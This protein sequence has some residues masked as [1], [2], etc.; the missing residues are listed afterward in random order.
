M[1]QKAGKK[2]G[3][4]KAL[5]HSWIKSERD[6]EKGKSGDLN[7]EELDKLLRFGAYHVLK[8]KEE[9]NKPQSIEDILASSEVME[10]A[11]VDQK[12]ETVF[13]QATFKNTLDGLDKIFD[14]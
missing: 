5:L 7:K 14:L 4:E 11:D 3:L 12:S 13:G 2:L 9:D 1:F 8:D 10:P 6:I